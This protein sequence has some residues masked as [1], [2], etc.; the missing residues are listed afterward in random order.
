MQERQ[1]EQT[2]IRQTFANSSESDLVGVGPSVEELVG[3]LVEND[4]IQLVSI[5]GI[6][7]IGKTTLARQVFHQTLSDV[8]LMDLHG[9]VFRNYLHISMF[10]TGFCK[11]FY[12]MIKRFCVWTKI[13]SRVNS[14]NCW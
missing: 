10:G 11:N 7:G 14:F 12:H 3:Q 4:N 6:S 13:Y 9:S 8:V 1:R 2:E 5:S